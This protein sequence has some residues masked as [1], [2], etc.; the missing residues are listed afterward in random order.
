M[1]EIFKAYGPVNLDRM[2]RERNVWLRVAD[3]EA[4]ERLPAFA[5][6]CR[7]KAM[8]QSYWLKKEANSPS[9]ETKSDWISEQKGHIRPD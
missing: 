1:Y 3:V 5:C 9:V 6:I 7:A 4:G 2:I 8:A